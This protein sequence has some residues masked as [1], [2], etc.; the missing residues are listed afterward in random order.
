MIF[1]QTI[2]FRVFNSTE[3]FSLEQTKCMSFEKNL[4]YNVIC[5]CFQSLNHVNYNK[6]SLCFFSNYK[7][8]RIPIA[9]KYYFSYNTTQP[10]NKSKIFLT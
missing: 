1:F 7:T 10:Y 5:E 6:I 9:K 4:S 3:V 2:L 8:L